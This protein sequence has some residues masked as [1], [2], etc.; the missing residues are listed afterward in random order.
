MPR[1][2]TREP[3]VEIRKLSADAMDVVCQNEADTVAE[4]Q[5]QMRAALADYFSI[6]REWAQA[7]ER[8]GSDA[9]PSP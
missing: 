5:R 9:E 3:G 6:L 4:E 7:K 1:R 2:R 8:V